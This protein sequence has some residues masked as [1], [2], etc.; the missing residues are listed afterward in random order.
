MDLKIEEIIV[1]YEKRIIE[2]AEVGIT[3]NIE[4]NRFQISKDD[5][6][7]R[8]NMIIRYIELYGTLPLW[9]LIIEPMYFK[10]GKKLIR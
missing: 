1:D 4:V 2:K 10:Q 7:H 3:G 6:Y 8:L 5:F 9:P